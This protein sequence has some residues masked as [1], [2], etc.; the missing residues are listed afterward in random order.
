LVFTVYS[1]LTKVILNKL[2]ELF[3]PDCDVQKG[4]DIAVNVYKRWI[5][6]NSGEWTV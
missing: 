4:N 3:I 1:F 6:S 2:E 5:A